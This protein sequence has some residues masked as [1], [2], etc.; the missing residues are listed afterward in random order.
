MK[1]IV[2]VGS[3]NMDIVN[4][5]N[6][7][8]LPGETI[9]G[10]GTEYMPGGK[11]ANQAVAAARC[12]GQVTMLG[13]VGN[14][15]FGPE[16]LQ[17]LASAGVRTDAVKVKAGTSG[18]AFIMV[19]EEGENSIILSEGA[20]GEL[21]KE[22]VSG[23]AGLFEDAYAVLLQ[24]E[25]PWPT[26]EAAMKAAR[27]AGARVVL[28]PAPAFELPA[29]AFSLIDVLI[30]NE[31]EAEVISGL[32]VGSLEQ[33]DLA[34]AEL[35]QRGIGTVILTLGEKGAL[36]ADRAGERLHTAAFPVKP[37]DTTA[38]GDTFIGAFA[39]AGAR[40]LAL[41]EALRFAAAAAA[42]TVTRKGAQESIPT[43]AE[44]ERLLAEAGL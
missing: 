41:A 26:T 19:D 1:H 27:A 29:E 13:A 28:N 23:A 37:V 8:P 32:P 40:G 16:L 18:L 30:L 3:I 35:V 20:N 5:V 38:A 7:H 21:T 39:S 10:L 43:Q 6:K 15:S 4:R 33:A 31:T 44:V 22:D 24:N 11:G 14:D 9:K 25:V 36:L 17:S 42:L 34:V 12:G 2:V